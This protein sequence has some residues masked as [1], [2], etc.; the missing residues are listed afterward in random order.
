MNKILG[1]AVATFVAASAGAANAGS[2]QIVTGPTSSIYSLPESTG[3]GSQAYPI[4]D[5]TRV[6]TQANVPAQGGNSEAWQDFAGLAALPVQARKASVLAAADNYRFEVIGRPVQNGGLGKIHQ[7]DSESLVWV[8][9]VRKQDGA[10]VPKAEVTLSRVDMAPGGMADMT[11]RSYVRTR[12]EPGKY[13]VEIHPLMAGLW[14]VSLA[15]QIPG[16]AEPVHGTV[17][18]PLVK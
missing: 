15:A 7:A 10:P 14:A 16:E 18:V 8:R 9:L 3:A 12:E 13:R 11:A 5:G 6:L 2:E 17:V 4:F 1:A